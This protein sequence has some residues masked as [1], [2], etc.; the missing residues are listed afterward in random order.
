MGHKQDC[1]W[2]NSAISGEE[3]ATSVL[4]SFLLP[5]ADQEGSR[6]LYL[7]DAIDCTEFM[8]ALCSLYSNF[9]LCLL[10]LVQANCCFSFNIFETH[11]V[12]SILCITAFCVYSLLSNTT[13]PCKAVS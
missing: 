1:T 4:V 8:F 5:G 10:L 12:K 2:T 13:A 6:F 11:V 9:F 3:H 7:T